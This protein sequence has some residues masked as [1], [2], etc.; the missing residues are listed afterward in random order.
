MYLDPIEIKTDKRTGKMVNAIDDYIKMRM[1]DKKSITEIEREILYY[2]ADSLKIFQA[3]LELNGISD[4]S[5][6]I[7]YYCPKC[8]SIFEEE[9]DKVILMCPKCITKKNQ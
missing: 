1:G 8:K 4:K 3:D 5:E 2:V 6:R 9:K 7:T